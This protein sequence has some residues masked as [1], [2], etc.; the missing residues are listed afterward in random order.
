MYGA[1]QREI[2]ETLKTIPEGIP[3]TQSSHGTPAGAVSMY[4][5]F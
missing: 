4:E 5:K 2:L 3:I 1:L